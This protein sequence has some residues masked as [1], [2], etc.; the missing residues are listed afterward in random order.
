MRLL[1]WQENILRDGYDIIEVIAPRGSG[2]TTLGVAWGMVACD[3]L[4]VLTKDRANMTKVVNDIK[5]SIS[6][7]VNVKVLASVRQLREVPTHP[8][9]RYKV[10]VDEYFVNDFKLDDI[11]KA[12][13]HTEYQ[14][15]FVGTRTK[16]EDTFKLPHSKWY[17]IQLLDMVLN[18][19]MS[20]T[21]IEELMKTRT[22]EEFLLDFNVSIDIN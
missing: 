6:G 20:P 13:G 8:K 14:I 1:S 21:A 10:L 22:Y 18:G 16:M 9:K 17:N 7:K 15:M 5:D 3:E 19:V 12:M 4:I 2:K 11:D